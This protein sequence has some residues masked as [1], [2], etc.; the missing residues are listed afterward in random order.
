M[1]N[2]DKFVW[3]EGEAEITQCIRCI[4]WLG[5][6]RCPAFSGEIPDAILTNEHD[7]RKPYPG[8]NGI[9]FEPIEG[10]NA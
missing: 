4:H 2:T 9:Q 5:R 7:H 10:N 3:K 1:I 6:K 8:D